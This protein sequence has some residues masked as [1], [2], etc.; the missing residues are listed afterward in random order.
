MQPVLNPGSIAIT[1]LCPNGGANKSWRALSAKR[2][3]AASS[4][5]ALAAA[6]VSVIIDGFISR[7]YASFIVQFSN[8][9]QQS[10]Q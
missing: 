6:R 5:F 1:R 2:F 4:A 9:E 3:I 7:R 10:V 8:F